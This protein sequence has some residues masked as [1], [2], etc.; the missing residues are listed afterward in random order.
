MWTIQAGCRQP[1]ALEPG[2]AFC[3]FRPV[4]TGSDPSSRCVNTPVLVQIHDCGYDTLP[5]T[6]TGRI[7]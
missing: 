6:P 5:N 7:C 2:A 4:Q 3:A 1:G